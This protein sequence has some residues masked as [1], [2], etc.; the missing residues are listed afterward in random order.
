MSN[1]DDIR[2]IFRR[3]FEQSERR[4]PVGADGEEPP[5]GGP[6]RANLPELPIGWWRDRR[7]WVGLILFL[8]F[9]SFNWI[10]TTYTDWLWYSNVGYAN[11]WITSWVTRLATFLVFFVIGVIVLWVNFRIALRGALASS[12]SVFK[13]GEFS[14]FK[15]LLGAVTAF[16]S[17][18]F[19]SA[20]GS[21]WE[22]LLQFI[23]RVSAGVSDPVYNLDLSFYFFQLPIYNFLRGW[24][25]PL[26]FFTLI[27]VIALYAIHNLEGLRG[28][29]IQLQNVD[30]LRR[31]GAILAAI[32]ALLIA[33][34][35][36]FDR[37]ELLYQ[38]STG[39]LV[40]GAGYT[41]LN[42]TARILILNATLMVVIAVIL[43]LNSRQLTLRP[44]IV[45][46]GLWLFS[47]IALNGIL[48]G[49]VE[50]TV[51][52]PNQLGRERPYL[53]YNIDSTRKAFA[54]DTIVVN[55]FGTVD[56]L[57]ESDLN[58]NASALNNI[59]LWDYRVLPD[60]YEQLQSLR[61]YYKFGDVDIDRYEINGE[62]RQVMLAARELEKSELSNQSWENLRLEFTHGY[63][64]VMN[65]VDRFTRDGQPEFFISDIPPVSTTEIEVTR[66]EIYYGEEIE[67][68]DIVFVGTERGEFDYPSGSSNV[69]T[70]YAGVGGV[71]IGNFLTKLA[72]A[73]RFGE[74]NIFINNDISNETR[75]M[76]H[77]QIS[78]RIK[79]IT[80]FLALDPDPYIVVADGRLVWM[81][82]AYTISN[83]YPY[84][85]PSSDSINY[86]RNAAKV[87]VDAYNGTVTY[88]MVDDEDPIT[89]TYARAFP[90]LF[91]P[92]SDM[93][94][95]LQAH[96]RYPEAMFRIQAQQNL[97][98]HMTDLTVF[99]N[100][101]DLWAISKETFRENETTE[102][103]PYYVNLTLP[104]E[105]EAEYLLIQPYT[106]AN[107]DNMVAWMAAR[108]DPP[109]YGE[110]VVYTLPKQQVVDGPLQV[111]AQIEQDSEISPQL[112]LWNEGSSQAIRGNLIVIPL[113]NSFL[114]VEP[115][116]LQSAGEGSRPELK[117]V[118]AASGGTVVMEDT[119][120]AALAELVNVRAFNLESSNGGSGISASS[121]LEGVELDSAI[122]DIIKSANESFTAAQE[123]QQA[124]DWAGYGE[125]LEQLEE[126]L[127][128]LE[129]LSQ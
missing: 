71:P 25:M 97:K 70:S 33:V 2:E 1:E 64:V 69:R 13:P 82:D 119:L 86:I 106:P 79:R 93:P 61:T 87:T 114:Y 8:L 15:L 120:A 30:N 84:S 34:G 31:H 41:D 17:F 36:L 101:E 47:L 49:I 57:Q 14:G 90:D 112:S 46:V 129:E 22:E 52:S 32:I 28:G 124:G 89:Q 73:V 19:A 50:R 66:P 5:E 107:K 11:V 88:Y 6:P 98:Y 96:I 9:I 105:T 103:E 60:N 54:L 125:A 122:Q 81:V 85:E 20:A 67:P 43:L 42:I 27:G 127:K 91:K 80:P 95:S 76:Y 53:Q 26:L 113:N 72:F 126:A 74:I 55:D 100:K 3:A 39:D 45:A 104:G 116:Y 111:E 21:M 23:Y 12:T 29:V 38:T 115:L 40:A 83:R 56:A 94:A 24:F 65:P 108:N 77:R 48:P 63:G 58:E 110:L 117:R 16:L 62:T 75:V 92:L 7:L 123:A 99:F 44:L 121:D 51:V 102:M 118:I 37:Y 68:D 109:H 128:L 35:H 78:E 10:V 4:A 59:R 18:S